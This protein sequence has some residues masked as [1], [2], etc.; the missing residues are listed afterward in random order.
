MA[1]AEFRRP[2]DHR[3]QFSAT[4]GP[5]N[6]RQ[7]I[8]IDALNAGAPRTID[9]NTNAN[10][11]AYYF[12][13]V[14]TSIANPVVAVAGPAPVFVRRVTSTSITINFLRTPGTIEL[15]L[16]APG[17]NYQSGSGFEIRNPTTGEI[18]FTAYDK[19]IKPVA[20]VEYATVGA[21]PSHLNFVNPTGR[22]VAVVMAERARY[23]ELVPD[24][25]TAG[26]SRNYISDAYS[27]TSGSGATTADYLSV[28]IQLGQ[29]DQPENYVSRRGYATVIDV[30]GY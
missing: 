1:F 2:S 28:I 20:V 29:A 15:F 24:D 21:A 10:G 22:K 6:L 16:F 7:K 30:E 5:L 12:L 18:L 19:P 27:L 4:R 13:T 25:P 9:G 3:L 8:S 17:A 14:A 26:S 11:V 23:V